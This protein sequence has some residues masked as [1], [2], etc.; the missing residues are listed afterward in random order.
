M[1]HGPTIFEQKFFDTIEKLNCWNFAQKE[2]GKK[3]HLKKPCAIVII[4]TQR[5]IKLPDNWFW[6]SLF[7][8]GTFFVHIGGLVMTIGW[9]LKRWEWGHAVWTCFLPKCYLSWEPKKG[10]YRRSPPI[11]FDG[12]VT[13]KKRDCE[14]FK[15]YMFKESNDERE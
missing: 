4:R 9:I 7:P 10:S 13:S 12:I 11:V 1:A 8:I 15:E 3:A 2:W 5:Q 6:K 14:C